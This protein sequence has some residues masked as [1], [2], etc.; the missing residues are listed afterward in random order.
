[1][2]CRLVSSVSHTRP[3]EFATTDICVVQNAE[4]QQA[5]FRWLSLLLLVVVVV[6]VMMMRMLMMMRYQYHKNTLWYHCVCNVQAEINR[7]YTKHRKI[8]SSFRDTQL[9]EIFELGINLLKKAYEMIKTV[10]YSDADQVSNIG[11]ISCIFFCIIQNIT[12]AAYSNKYSSIP[13]V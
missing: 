5:R 8:A 10:D 4:L 7:S 3:A 9:F 11:V 1:M 12:N 6:V 2:T 13:G